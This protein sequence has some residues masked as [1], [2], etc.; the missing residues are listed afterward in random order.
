MEANKKLIFIDAQNNKICIIDKE[1]REYNWSELQD[2]SNEISGHQ[3][4]YVT[5]VE[6]VDGD[7]ILSLL[8]AESGVNYIQPVRTGSKFIHAS[9]PGEIIVPYK[10]ADYHP[11]VFSNPID[12]K[13]FS[14][15]LIEM[16]PYIKRYMEIGILEIVDEGDIPRIKKNYNTKLTE[17]QKKKQSAKDKSLNSMLVD[18]SA[19]RYV[20]K[21][22]TEGYADSL[23]SGEIDITDDINA[24]EKGRAETE[25]FYKTAKEAGISLDNMDEE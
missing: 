15:E 11:L 2:I 6:I 8:S 1:L 4:L 5:S 17:T 21:I 18:G 14:N 9:R 3:V 10:D 16:Y 7:D 19:S 20:D 13:P 12:F 24:A 23:D 25:D 22:A